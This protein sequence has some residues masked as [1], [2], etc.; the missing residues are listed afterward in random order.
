MLM[1]R[2]ALPQEKDILAEIGLTAWLKGIRPLVSAEVAARIA[3]S[4]PFLPFLQKLGPRVLIAEIDGEPAGLG[5]CEGDNDTISDVWVAPPFEGRGAG[6]ALIRALE[7]QI[8]GRGY[9][10][11]H[12]QVAALNERALQL[13][14]HLGY[15]EVW[16]GALYDPIL[17]T[18][19]EKIGLSRPL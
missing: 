8:A 19:L 14:L 7:A 13:Y 18:N 9:A 11:A 16:R 10:E 12:I 6:S 15:R 4:N 5:A 2:P 17:E 3:A 1:I